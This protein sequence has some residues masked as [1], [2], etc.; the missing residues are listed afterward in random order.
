MEELPIKSRCWGDIWQD[1]EADSTA[2]LIKL[3][4]KYLNKSMRGIEIGS[5]AGVS[6]EVLAVYCKELFCIDPWTDCYD[7]NNYREISR[8]R[9]EKAESDFDVIKNKYNN[10][11]KIKDFSFNV[12]ARF[13]PHEFDFIYI[14]GAHDEQSARQDILT[15]RPLIKKGGLLMGH[16]EI[17]IRSV[18]EDLQLN[19]VEVFSDTSW[20]SLA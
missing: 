16:D 6:S 2:G 3:C 18:I 10:I 19:I 1:Y 14:D 17:M 13:K 12:Y 9:L 5:F 15:Y 20:V 4:K 11:I 8:E 7:L